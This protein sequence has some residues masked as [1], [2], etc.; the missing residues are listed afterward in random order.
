ML[1]TILKV[2]LV[3]VGG[4]LLFASLMFLIE[5]LH[6]VN[7]QNFSF[8]LALIFYYLNYGTQMV[9]ERMGIETSL[10]LLFL[11]GLVQWSALSAAIGAAIHCFGYKK[12]N[13]VS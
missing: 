12:R 3:L 11:G 9:L 5:A 6:G 4:H 7:D 1:R 13:T 10:M 8:A 2:G